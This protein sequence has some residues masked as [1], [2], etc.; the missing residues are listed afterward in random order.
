L[1]TGPQTTVRVA[2]KDITSMKVMD[3]SMMPQGL[4]K[5]LSEQE[6]ADLMAFLI[7]QD[8]DPDKDKAFLR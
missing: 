1:K 4:D 7:G 2:R 3:V 5:L 8:Q 6:M